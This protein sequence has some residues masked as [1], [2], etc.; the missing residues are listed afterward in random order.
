MQAFDIQ[1]AVVGIITAFL[2]EGAKR[3]SFIPLSEGNKKAIRI[4][5]FVLGFAG[6]LG[7]K[8][9]DGTASDVSFWQ[10]VAQ[11]A[12]SYLFS[13]LTYKSVIK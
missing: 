6:V 13:Y 2:V 1:T 7:G 9:L 10:P 3:V 5:T 12:V 4:T 11:S 8:I